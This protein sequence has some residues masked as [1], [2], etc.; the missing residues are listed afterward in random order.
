MKKKA[1]TLIELLV[2]ISIIALLIAI[3]LPVLGAARESAKAMICLTNVRSLGQAAANFNT[4]N[5]GYFP[6]PAGS[7]SR[8][9][10]IREAC[11]Y[12]SLDE[13]VGLESKGTAATADDR[14][15]QSFKQD[16]IWEDFPS[17]NRDYNR[18]IKMN[19]YFGR[20]AP[21]NNVSIFGSNGDLRWAKIEL[22]ESPSQTVIFGDGLAE[23]LITT[24]DDPFD[25][26]VPGHGASAGDVRKLY[27]MFANDVALRHNGGANI[28]LVDGSAAL[29]QMETQQRIIQGA[30]VDVWY[31][32]DQDVNPI[33]FESLG[34]QELIWK[35]K[36]VDSFGTPPKD[37]PFR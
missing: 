34:R 1:F 22:I 21:L 30:E 3:L 16:P 17:N 4:D 18:T 12:N 37:A 32:E 6:Q 9:T 2:V 8:I 31:T 14:E 25:Y 27:S 13:Y 5:K 28:G 36:G 35:I 24:G 20:P 33:T 23:D 19:S 29:Y 7:E 10:N 11:W 26:S 15:D